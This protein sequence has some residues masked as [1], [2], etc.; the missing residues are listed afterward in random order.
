MLSN[1]C[2]WETY[3][4]AQLCMLAATGKVQR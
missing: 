4:F 3:Y 1:N 2:N